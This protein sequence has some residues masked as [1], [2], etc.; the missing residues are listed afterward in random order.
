MQSCESDSIT[1]YME[2]TY[3]WKGECFAAAGWLILCILVKAER[4]GAIEYK[5]GVRWGEE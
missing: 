4:G 3:V 1:A 2:V 5:M